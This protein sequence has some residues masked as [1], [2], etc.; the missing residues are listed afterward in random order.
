MNSR[1]DSVALHELHHGAVAPGAPAQRGDEVRIRQAA[2]VEHEIG[3]D[4]HAVLVAE[5][6]QRDDEPRPRAR[7]ATGP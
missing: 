3:V 4:R 2:H 7:R 1:L 6:E 5:A